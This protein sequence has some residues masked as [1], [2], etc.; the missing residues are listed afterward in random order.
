MYASLHKLNEHLQQE[1]K[2]LLTQPPRQNV[3]VL[4]SS[5]LHMYTGLNC[6]AF[7]ILL[8]YMEPV[9]PSYGNNP[10]EIYAMH[11]GVH[12]HPTTSQKLLMTLMQIRRR[13]LEYGLA[14]R[15]VA[16]QSTVSRTL[17]TWISMLAR[18]L[19]QLIQWPQTI[20]GP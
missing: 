8:K 13:L 6:T 4:S 16:N 10:E 1:V 11:Q 19:E 20:I 17:N 2:A 18:Q 9:V 14:V 3:C 12:T 15:F 5:E 7:D